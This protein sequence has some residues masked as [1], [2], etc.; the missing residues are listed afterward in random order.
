V[1]RL[2]ISLIGS[3]ATKTPILADIELPER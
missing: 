1:A 3:D 2:Q